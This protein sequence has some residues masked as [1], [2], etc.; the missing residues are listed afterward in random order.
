VS[1][2]PSDTPDATSAE[3]GAVD[4]AERHLSP[5]IAAAMG[6]WPTALR[7]ALVCAALSLPFATCLTLYLLIRK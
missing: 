4:W 1:I 7:F 6:S 5:L 3:L 2:R